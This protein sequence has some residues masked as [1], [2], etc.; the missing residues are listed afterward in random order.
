MVVLIPHGPP[1]RGHV[2]CGS[3]QRICLQLLASRNQDIETSHVERVRLLYAKQVSYQ[4][5]LGHIRSYVVVGG[6]PNVAR[7]TTTPTFEANP[8]RIEHQSSR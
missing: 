6:G 8:E 1:L 7:Q 5:W 4:V 2:V 3:L